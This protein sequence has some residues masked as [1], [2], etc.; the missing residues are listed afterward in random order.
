MAD[1]PAVGRLV[2]HELD[3]ASD[4]MKD[5]F[6]GIASDLM[7]GKSAAE[8]LSNALQKVLDKLINRGIDSLVDSLFK[9]G[10]GIFSGLFGGGAAGGSGFALPTQ[11][12]AGG[13]SVRARRPYIVGEHRPELFVRGPSGRIVRHL[14]NL[15][16]AVGGPSRSVTVSPAYNIDARGA[17]PAAITRLEQGLAARDRQFGRNV[18]AVNRHTNTR[19]TRA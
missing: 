13:G 15:A 7:S 5:A 19:G 2:R 12:P 4:T 17:D 14:P 11:R 3:F 18:Q 1:A 8:A 9:G 10:G 16:G 6:K